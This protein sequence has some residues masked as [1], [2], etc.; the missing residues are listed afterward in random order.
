MLSFTSSKENNNSCF[1]LLGTHSL[2]GNNTESNLLFIN[3]IQSTSNLFENGMDY[4]S[5][6]SEP[7]ESSILA[8]GESYDNESCG[9]VAYS[10]SGESCGSIAYSGGGESCGSIASAGFSSGASSCCCSYSC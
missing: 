8:F 3:S 2:L 6:Y 7:S 5:F 9:S 1:C 4:C 10:N